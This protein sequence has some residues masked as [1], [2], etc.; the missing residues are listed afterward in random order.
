M[1]FTEDLPGFLADF[2]V[3]MDFVGAPAG[4]LAIF[5]A[6]D[7]A[8]LDPQGHLAVL[9]RFTTVRVLSSVAALLPVE[10]ELTVDSVAYVV[11][12]R[13]QLGDGVFTRLWLVTL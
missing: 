13:R 7:E 6:S 12:D 4:A 8:V 11:R 1:A 5:D 3:P 2:G 10:T 9:G